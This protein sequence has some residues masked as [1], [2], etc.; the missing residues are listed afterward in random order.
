MAFSEKVS[1]RREKG[2]RDCAV[3][4]DIAFISAPTFFDNEE[5]GWLLPRCETGG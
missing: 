1:G 5:K 3:P 4:H 2:E